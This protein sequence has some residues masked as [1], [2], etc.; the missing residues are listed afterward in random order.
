MTEEVIE[1]PQETPAPEPTTE[2][3]PEF[4][5]E[6]IAGALGV[7]V[8]FYT[9]EVKPNAKNFDKMYSK[10]NA[11][12]MALAEQEKAAATKPEPEPAPEPDEDVELDAKAQKALK[13]FIE[14]EFGGYFEA[15]QQTAT[16]SVEAVI[17]EF[18][19]KAKDVDANR[20]TEVM[21]ELGLWTRNASQ[22]KKNFDRALK[23]VKAESAE[24]D[25]E[26]KAEKLAQERLERLLEEKG[27]KDA[28]VV[29]V[30]KSPKVE[31][32][33]NTD[34]R[35]VDDPDEKFRLLMA[36]QNIKS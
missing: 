19:E 9:N 36:R 24:S 14:S 22:L 30:K 21:D 32:I 7:D 3:P 33:D 27:L 17:E 10:L 16:A 25:L 20:V 4:T 28:E 11:R 26:A 2:A 34:W 31:N 6:Q 29:S 23:L 8:E 1:T 18:S 12:A 13:R 15:I 5:D 35:E